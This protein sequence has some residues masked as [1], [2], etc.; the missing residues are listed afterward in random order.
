MTNVNQIALYQYI[1]LY[2]II[3]EN[4][5][6]YLTIIIPKWYKKG[7]YIYQFDIMLNLW[8]NMYSKG[9]GCYENKH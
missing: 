1:I 4:N 6:N 7:E 2:V 5:S 9:R 3:L 8:Y